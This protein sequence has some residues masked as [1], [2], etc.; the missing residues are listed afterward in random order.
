MHFVTT[1]SLVCFEKKILANI[2]AVNLQKEMSKNQSTQG[3]Q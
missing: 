1:L 3:L 2:I